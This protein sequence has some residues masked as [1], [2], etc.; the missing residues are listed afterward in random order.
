VTDDAQLNES[1]YNFTVYAADVAAP[2]RHAFRRQPVLRVG[3]RAPEFC[4]PRT[5]G[6]SWDLRRELDDAHVV[7][8]FGCL[9]APPCLAEMPA[10]DR[11]ARERRDAGVTFVFVYTREHHPGE[12]L[13][14]HRT[15]EQKLAQARAFQQRTGLSFP[16]VADQVDGATHRAYG[17]LP[18]MAA[19]VHRSG[20]L[21]HRAEWAQA[22]DLAGVLDNLVE[23]DRAEAGGQV[24]RLSFTESLRF[25]EREDADT[26]RAYLSLAG[27]QAL[28]DVAR[29]HVAPEVG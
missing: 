28:A 9:S 25:D 13:P 3:D 29:G 24:G 17:Q 5:D 26:L 21:I 1:E 8:V 15:I 4:L 16:V 14:P 20:S 12:L 2:D 11:L 7:V 10:I 23:R 19:V 27:G 22:S 18:F 6:N